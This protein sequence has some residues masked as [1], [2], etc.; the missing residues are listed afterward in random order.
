MDLN[1]NVPTTIGQCVATIPG[2]TYALS[3]YLNVNP[4]CGT[5]EY[6]GFTRAQGV[7]TMTFDSVRG[8]GWKKE[9]LVF[10]ATAMATLIEFGSTTVG[11]CGPVIDNVVMQVM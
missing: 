11:S 9:S 10:T 8:V 6:T 1:P 4:S 2:T 3:F 5:S 7:A